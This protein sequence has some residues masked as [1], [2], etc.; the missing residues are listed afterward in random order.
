MEET[1]TES[2]DD[3]REELES[4]FRKIQE[5]DILTG[6]VL[7]VSEDGVILDLKY[8]AQGVIRAEDLSN[9]PTFSIFEEIKPGDE[10]SA[11][12]I[13]MDDGH[14]NIL[15]SRKEAD[16]ILAWDKLKEYQEQDAVL[17]VKVGG[18]VNA[19]VIA[20]VEGVRGFIPASQLSIKYVEDCNDWLNRTLDVK[21]I[22][23]DPGKKKLVLS[24]KVVEK[25]REE[26]ELA[27]RIA[28]LIPGT[29][30][31]GTVET[32]MPYGAFLNIGDGLSGLVH[33]SQISQRR[34]ASPNEV[35]KTGQK[36]RAKILNTNDGKISLSMKALED[37]LPREEEREAVEY[38]DGASATT[39][40]GDLLKNIKL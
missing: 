34:I 21:I 4:S 1:R 8:Y 31:E 32:I 5:G 24:G 14:G 29:V 25:E 2:M 27:H 3:Y 33:I 11:T 13:R 9:D 19:G 6:T 40:L 17:T 15:L 26:A 28:M 39:S 23:L 38:S 30:V 35:L 22:T 20:Y 12:V 37:I 36:V 18:I 7:D 16:D 10:I